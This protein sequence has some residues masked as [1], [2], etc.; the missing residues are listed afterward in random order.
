[1]DKKQSGE[2][3]QDPVLVLD[4]A[5]IRGTMLPRVG[6][7]AANL[8]ELASVGLP[9]PRGF[10]LT[11]AAYRQALSGVGLESVLAALEEAS[12]SGTSASGMDASDLGASDLGASGMDQLNELAARARSLVLDAGVPDGIAEA[13]RSAYEDFGDNVPVAVRSSATAEDLPF[14]SFAGQQDTFLN[15]VG[16]DS[17]LDAVSRCWASLWTDRAV[18]YRT[19]N[20]IDHG[21]V[22]LAVVV[23]EMV[24]AVTAGVMFTANPVTGNRYQTVIDASPGL[25]EAV[26]SGAVNPDHYIV[27]AH[28]SAIVERA[29]GDRQVEIRAKPGGGTE[30]LERP[31]QPGIEE[32]QPCLSDRQVLELAKL[33]LEV[34]EHYRAPQDTEW[35]IDDDGKLWLTQARPITTLYPQT[36]RTP[37]APG[38]HAFL[39]FS[40]AQGLTRPLTPM[41]LAGIRLIASSVAKTAAFDVPDPRSGPPA[42]Y[43]AGQRIFFDFTAVLRSRVGRTIVPRVFDV[44]EARS[45]AIM[46][47][48]FDDPRFAVTIKTPRK[49]IRHVA[50]VAAKYR[51]PESLFRGLF[52][53]STAMRRV[54]RLSTELRSTF[55][56]PSGATPHQRLGH[57]Q[58]ILGEEVFATVPQVL[59]LPA[60]GFAM[61]ALVRRI[62][63]DQ[64]PYSELQT[65]VRGLPN[66]VTTEMD[67]ALW[68]VASEI[69]E[70]PAAVA[71][72]VG[73]T[74]AELVEQYRAAKLPAAAQTGLERF[75]GKYGH[76]AVAEID[77]GMPRWSDDP[78]HILGVIANYLRLSDGAEAPDQQFTQAALDADE[79]VARFV[80]RARAKSPLHAVIVRLALDRTRRFAGL[81]ELPKYNL[82]L[83]LSAARKQLFLIGNELVA[84]RR[85]ER[86][87]DIF[88]LD[89]DDVEVALAGDD[90]HEV[91]AERR[92]AYHQELRRR[93]IPRV[94]LS[95]GTEPEATPGRN[96]GKQR[97]G[98][99]SGSPASAGLVSAPARV[100][101]DPVGAHLEPGE[102][103]VAPSTDPGWTP[104]FLTAGGLV[105]EMGGPNSHGAVVAREYGIPAVVGVPDATSR[106]STGQHITVDGAAGTVSTENSGQ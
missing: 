13:V 44:M 97:P 74:P 75:L 4:I 93:H 73:R 106:I 101:M 39:N 29:V 105:M 70:D 98:T 94:L 16:V 5:E 64:A 43:E 56:V 104:L 53:P 89:L 54:E 81:R 12:A 92:A 95:D 36:T 91:V 102:I 19:T 48:L 45:A 28:R 63:G 60:L 100:I 47:G 23:Q 18:T 71:S 30:R 99:L 34:Q 65:V 58:R 22:S 66:N 52:R 90:V 15:I 55:S 38:E 20:G 50:P 42:Y 2:P 84:A 26:V 6:G 59:P 33:G 68:Q 87:E 51:V 17:V 62:L 24:N 9:V 32:P 40:L 72:M 103:L 7:K 61:L 25:G 31:G 96:E 8:G 1:M 83:G 79:Q 86:V 77:L 10:C 41:G 21:T 35:A 3:S 14:A 37:P 57:V 49:L 69:R 76:R 27:D 80:A 88:F 67:L 82:V 85:I 78:T 46:R 11:T